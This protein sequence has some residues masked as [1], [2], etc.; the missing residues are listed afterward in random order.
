MLIKYVTKT[1]AVSHIN[2]VAALKNASR[3]IVFSSFSRIAF[4]LCWNDNSHAYNFNTCKY[5][6][7]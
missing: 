6:A 3:L 1:G 2:V 4:T 5:Y 7:F